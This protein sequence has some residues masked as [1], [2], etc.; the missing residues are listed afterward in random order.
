MNNPFV[1]V[2][3]PNYNHAR[4]LNERIQSVLNQTYQDFEL[5]ILDDKSSDNSKDVIELYRNNPHVTHIIYNEQNSG[6]TF[7]QWEKG[8]N[9]AKGEY[10]WLAESDDSCQKT[11]LEKLVAQIKQNANVSVA[12]VHSLTFD[13][14]GNILGGLRPIVHPK[15]WDGKAFI[16]KKMCMGNTIDNASMAV[17]SRRKALEIGNTYQLY[18]GAGDY[19]FW[20][21]MA[22]KG[23]VAEVS[24]PLNLC[25]IHTNKVTNRREK[26]GSNTKARK[27]IF[28][29]LNE[30]GYVSPKQRAVIYAQNRNLI[31]ILC[32]ELNIGEKHKLLSLWDM[33][34]KEANTILKREDLRNKIKT[35]I[36][37]VSHLF[38][39]LKKSV[40]KLLYKSDKKE[41]SQILYRF[42]S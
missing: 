30:K 18:I 20:I 19:L 29:Y 16:K 5:I 35:I 34:D 8:I 25:R 4:F 31:N 11:L 2:I 40:I 38:F 36:L 33:D 12:F 32:S 15:I 28:D 22:E 17:F 37:V 23:N 42:N 39:Y 3:I 7:K 24:E 14:D 10:V 13:Q 21:M 6:S 9:L 27:G 1:S 41:L 26:D